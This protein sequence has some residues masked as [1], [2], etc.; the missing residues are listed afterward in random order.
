MRKNK[1]WI[2]SV[3]TVVVIVIACTLLVAFKSPDSDVQY[4]RT[5]WVD[6]THGTTVVIESKK[7]L[8]EYFSTNKE[9]YNLGHK[10]KVYADTTIGF[11]DAVEEYDEEYFKEKALVIVL[12]T[13]SSGSIRH[14]VTNVSVKDGIMEIKIERVV[15]EIGTCDMAGWH[16][17]VET[18]KQEIEKIS[19]VVDGK[20]I[21]K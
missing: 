6:G 8:D 4:I 10:E 13:E 11:V 2:V 21:G 5:N 19:V 9:K 16:V 14:K 20:E 1:K 12:L 3:V 18:E 17:L 15:P 7:E